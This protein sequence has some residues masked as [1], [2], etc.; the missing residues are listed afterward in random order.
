[1]TSPKRRAKPI[2]IV[3]AGGHAKVV[4][5][6]LAGAGRR[7]LGALDPS[8]NR[9]ER[10]LCGLPLL[11]DDSWLEGRR[12]GSLEAAVGVGANPDVAPRRRIQLRLKERGL[13]LP[14]VVAPSASVSLSATLGE[15]AQ[16]LTRAVVHPEARVGEGAVVNTAAV[17][18]HDV[19]MGAF[20][21]AAPGA[22]L[23]GNVKLGDGAFVGAA[24]VVLPGVSVGAGAVVGAGSVVL[25]DVPAGAR[26]AGNPARPLPASRRGPRIG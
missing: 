16:V 15:G 13:R 21:F 6:A 7:V 2:V 22:V 23:C 20:S 9:G 10:A 8:F 5:D 14:P 26:V 25:R 18:E 1:M 4:A 11:G 24:A 17:V 12:P 3:G 19:V